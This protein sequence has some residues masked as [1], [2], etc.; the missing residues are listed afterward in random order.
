MFAINFANVE[1]DINDVSNIYLRFLN[2]FIKKL[3]RTKA[4]YGTKL[5]YSCQ[6]I[7]SVK[8]IQIIKKIFINMCVFDK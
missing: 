1:R 5:Q 3:T 8:K 4:Q 7:L 6:L 2:I